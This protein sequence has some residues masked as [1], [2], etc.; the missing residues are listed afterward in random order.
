M[1]A[2]A[3]DMRSWIRS[4]WGLLV[5]CTQRRFGLLQ[6]YKT[7]TKKAALICFPRIPTNLGDCQ[8]SFDGFCN[9]SY[10]QDLQTAAKKSEKGKGIR[11]FHKEQKL[12]VIK[13]LF[14]EI[15]HI[16][17]CQKVKKYCSTIIRESFGQT[18]KM[19]YDK[20]CQC[21]KMLHSVIKWMQWILHVTRGRHCGSVG[22]KSNSSGKQWGCQRASERWREYKE[23]RQK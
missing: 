17:C 7:T 18:L 12:W 1:W 19:T 22:K 13:D 8:H 23:K 11:L 2:R 16:V 4:T 9:V 21:S 14:F 10:R 3:S 5:A 15:I 6:L 20:I